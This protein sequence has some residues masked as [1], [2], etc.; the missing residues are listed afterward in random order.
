MESVSICIQNN[1]ILEWHFLLAYGLFFYLELESNPMTTSPHWSCGSVMALT[2]WRSGFNS[3]VKHFKNVLFLDFWNKL[4]SWDWK[5]PVD[6]RIAT[7]WDLITSDNCGC[8]GCTSAFPLR[9]KVR[10]DAFFLLEKSYNSY[11]CS[12]S[13]SKNKF[14]RFM[15]VDS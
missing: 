11:Y 6:H 4:R 1:S 12:G 5:C 9:G 2:T 7:L 10:E 14:C 8:I 3:R 15:C 13:F